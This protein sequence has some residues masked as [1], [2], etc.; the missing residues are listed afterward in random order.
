MLRVH[1]GQTTQQHIQN[2]IIEKSK[3]LL[4]TTSLSVSEIAY[5][6]GFEHPQSFHRL[7]KNRTS[8]SPLEF[9][10]SFN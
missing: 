9:R 1:T 2:R 5:H 10:Q 3:E 6:L 4:S 8:I 7:F